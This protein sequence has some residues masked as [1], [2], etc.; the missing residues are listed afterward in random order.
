MY[1]YLGD[2]DR[3]LVLKQGRSSLHI[4]RGELLAVTTPLPTTPP[5]IN[6]E[7]K[8]DAHPH[9]RTPRC[10]HRSIELGQDCAVLLDR[11]VEVLFIQHKHTVVLSKL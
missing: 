5:S 9:T 10:T 11:V 8:T 6:A 1:K 7:D 2:A 4:L 3:I